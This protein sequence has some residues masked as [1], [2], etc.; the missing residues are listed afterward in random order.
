MSKRFYSAQSYNKGDCALH[1]QQTT[2]MRGF[3]YF[4]AIGVGY[5]SHGNV[6]RYMRFIMSTFAFGDFRFL[7][8]F[9]A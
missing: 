2:G 7:S 5:C 8:H 3:E 1:S 4:V 9:T 6:Y